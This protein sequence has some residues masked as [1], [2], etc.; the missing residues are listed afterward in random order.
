MSYI[1]SA[2]IYAYPDGDGGVVVHTNRVIDQGRDHEP[3]RYL[4]SL[5]PEEFR[6]FVREVLTRTSPSW[7]MP[8]MIEDYVEK[9]IASEKI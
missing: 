6:E 1:K 9:F 4:V 2:D 8:R 7:V 3:F 5:R